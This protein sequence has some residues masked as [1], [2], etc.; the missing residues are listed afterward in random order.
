L[1][2]RLDENISYRVVRALTAALPDR[3]GYEVTHVSDV[4]QPSTKD[5]DWLR[6]FAADGGTAIIS[7]DFNILRNWP[8][9]VAYTETGLISFF[10]PKGF[11]ALNR[12]GK[13]AFLIRWWP[14]IIEQIKLSKAGDRWRLPM[15][16]E[17]SHLGMT[18]LR[19]PRVT[20]RLISQ[21]PQAEI[22]SLNTKRSS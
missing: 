15:K 1:K 3:Q 8:D 5:P 16:W 14:A 18:F 11:E 22:I 6:T 21:Q 7:G 17:P 19:D 10:P 13:A 4:H 2:I 12:F 20:G 9:L